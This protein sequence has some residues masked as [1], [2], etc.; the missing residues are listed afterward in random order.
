MK[1][2]NKYYLMRHGQAILNVKGICSSWPEKFKNPLTKLGR[3]MVKASVE[4]FKASGKSVD[5]IINSPLLRCRQTAAIAGKILGDKS[6]IDKRLREIG[7]GKFNGKDLH[8]MW[9]SFKYEKERINKGAD[10]GETYVQILDR[11]T[12]VVE[13]LEKKYDGKN[14]MLISH[15]G[16]LFLLQGKLM[17]LSI[18]ETIA[19][20]PLEKRIHK[21]EIREIK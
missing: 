8:L 12:A 3:E 19:Y 10:G 11:M 4:K 9:K 13:D 2:N 16:T 15:E 17:G 18:E 14:I 1:L 5:M 6:R 21:A 20:F 7:F